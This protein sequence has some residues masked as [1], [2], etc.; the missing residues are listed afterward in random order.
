VATGTGTGPG[1]GT[2]PGLVWLD[3]LY[4]QHHQ[5]LRKTLLRRTFLFL[6]VSCDGKKGRKEERKKRKKGKKIP[7][8]ETKALHNQ[9]HEKYSIVT[10]AEVVKKSVTEK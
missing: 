8:N 7:H 4:D 2:G 5:Y 9:V 10:P 1:P 3:R 6:L